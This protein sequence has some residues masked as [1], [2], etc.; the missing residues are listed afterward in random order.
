MEP[1]AYKQAVK[2]MEGHGFKFTAENHAKNVL[3]F[4]KLF[5]DKKLHLHAT[6]T[7]ATH[8]IDLDTTGNLDLG[9]TLYC[10]SI[11]LENVKFPEFEKKLF[12]YLYL[13]VYGKPICPVEEYSNN[14]LY[15]KPEPKGE[16]TGGG[17]PVGGGEEGK[18]KPSTKPSIKERKL[19]FWEEV[20][21][22]AKQKGY[23][24]ELAIEFYTYW[25][26]TNEKNTA[27][28]REKENFFDIPKRFA[29]WI[30]N[31][32]KWANKTFTVKSVEVQ[33]E[34]VKNTNKN[35]KKHKDLF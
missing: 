10:D 11:D 30:K 27:F 22:V 1:F 34:E 6:V 21:G 3:F 8:L 25:S 16:V 23:P 29:T 12:N 13:C 17:K 4:L 5:D 18:G 15:F 9:I 28:R 31:D 2:V 32:K 24:K 19:K 35:I 33:E 14:G 26:E 7:L 20:K